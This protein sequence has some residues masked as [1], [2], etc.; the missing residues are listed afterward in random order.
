MAYRKGNRDQL[1]MLPAAIDDYVPSNDPVRVYDAVIEA[2]NVTD[3]GLV[4]DSNRVGNSA[5]EP[6]TMLKLLVY[7]YSYGWKSSRKLERATCHNLSFIWLMGGLKPD[8][9]TIANFRKNNLQTI[10]R[11]LKQTARICL[12]LDLIN[13]NCLFLD[14]SKIRGSASINQTKSR[15]KWENNLEAVDKRIEELL[16]ECE[17]VDRQEEEQSSYVKISKELEDQQ[18]LKDK[19]QSLLVTLDREDLSKINGTDPACINYKS[20]Q[21]SH[22]GLNAQ[23][24]TDDK[25]GLIVNADVVSEATDLNQ[26]SNQI[27]QANETLG[28]DCKIAVADAGYAKPDAIEATIEKGIDVIVPSRKQAEHKPKADNP[29]SKDKFQYD[30]E[31]NQYVCP[32][33]KTLTYTSFDKNKNHFIYRIKGPSNCRKCEHFGICTK[34]K[35]GRQISRMKNEELKEYL[36]SRYS[37]SEGQAIYKKRK[38][39]SEHPFGHIKRNLGGDHFLMKGLKAARGELSLFSSCFNIARMMTL[40]GGVEATLKKLHALQM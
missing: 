14:G 38:E 11:V 17:Q 13:G 5:Y 1:S 30:S 33:G 8:H 18:K 12:Q 34:N 6:K 36:E 2:M 9:K 19:I 25:H 39:K 22:A 29:F 24:V 15:K 16:T 3:L 27:E 20:R 31:N 7:G 4:I 26:F 32:E 37:S 23:L 28:K 40:L 10:K 35:K 21:G